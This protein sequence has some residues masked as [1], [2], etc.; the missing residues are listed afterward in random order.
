MLKPLSCS[1]TTSP[2]TI[3]YCVPGNYERVA[4]RLGEA[5]EHSSG[6]L[7]RLVPSRGGVLEIRID[8]RLVFSKRATGRFPEHDEILYHLQNS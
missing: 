2:V 7:P 4:R 8:G 6:I 1:S 3:E 5:I